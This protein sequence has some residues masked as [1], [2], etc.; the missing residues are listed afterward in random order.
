MDPERF[1]VAVAVAVKD[2]TASLEEMVRC[3]EL[4]RA[5]WTA[6]NAGWV[7]GVPEDDALVVRDGKFGSIEHS[8]MQFKA[9]GH[10]LDVY[11]PGVLPQV[12]LLDQ[13]VTIRDYHILG[14]RTDIRQDMVK[15]FVKEMM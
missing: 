9:T 14:E 10:I 15:R 3:H 7:S 8:W 12:L 6:L 2:K 13:F 4:T 5:V 11:R 1:G